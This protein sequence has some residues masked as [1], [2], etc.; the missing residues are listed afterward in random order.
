MPI[1]ENNS[2]PTF[3]VDGHFIYY[4][5]EF[6]KTLGI[7]DIK[8]I[9]AHETMHPALFHLTRIG[10]R[11]YIVWNMAGDYVINRLL[12]DSGMK[13]PAD[14]LL[15]EKYDKTWATEK[16]YDD[17]MK[18]AKKISIQCLEDMP[19]TGYFE[20]GEGQ[21][22]A[23]KA[24]TENKWKTKII[25]AANA[26]SKNR[27]TIPGHFKE[28]INQIRNP[29]VD[30]R[31]KLYALATEPMR[32]EHSW[33]RPNRRFI[34]KDLY[35]PS[36]T[37]IDGLRKIIFAV[38]TSGSMNTDLLIDAWSEIVSV[39]EDCDVDELIIMD[40][41]TD[42]NHIRRFSKDD[43]PDAL[44]VVGRGGTAFEPAFDWV[45]ENDEDPAV[46]IYFTDL[47]GSF[48]QHEPDYPVIW[49]NYGAKD[50]LCPFGEVITIE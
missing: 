42:V 13:P 28:L 48:P 47:Y 26:C 27:G 32:D 21:S 23:D 43:L 35:L 30:W 37:K 16:T 40:V 50:T 20:N 6:I 44:E 4:N 34:G 12:V 2:I 9:L 19:S 10:T 17:L 18:N 7:E 3:A 29:K 22:E 41:D 15:D 5:S 31:D 46:L 14:A 24:E 36:I 11:D 39:V 38:D 49:V 45:I 8:F 25:A 33:R 1:K